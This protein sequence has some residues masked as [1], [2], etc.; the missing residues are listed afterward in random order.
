[1]NNIE[2]EIKP[3]IIIN[4]LNNSIARISKEKEMNDAIN[5]AIIQQQK[6]QIAKMSS[7][8][9]ILK[10]KLNEYENKQNNKTK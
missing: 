1:M 3:E 5:L 10:N 4:N 8:I 7:E 9:E 2:I 6:E